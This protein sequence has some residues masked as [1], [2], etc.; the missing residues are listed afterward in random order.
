MQNQL[1]AADRKDLCGVLSKLLHGTP[2]TPHEGFVP[3]NGYGLGKSS[4]QLDLPSVGIVES[5]ATFQS[6]QALQATNFP[7]P[8]PGFPRVQHA[9]LILG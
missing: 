2:N 8:A 9:H 7:T 3:S 1:E 6:G 4:I 5:I